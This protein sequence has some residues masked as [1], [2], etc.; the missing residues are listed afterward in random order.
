MDNN[1]QQKGYNAFCS[2]NADNR[3]R[4]HGKAIPYLGWFWR[5]IDFTGPPIPIGK[6][7][8]PGE[9]APFVGFMVNN[10]WGYPER[11]LTEGER[12]QV[13]AYLDK[14]MELEGEDKDAALMELWDYM[15]TLNTDTTGGWEEAWYND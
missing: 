2:E 9:G 5:D 8:H 13:I 15:Q 11:N 12:L 14:A 10:K 4:P 3:D 7:T 1:G 6:C